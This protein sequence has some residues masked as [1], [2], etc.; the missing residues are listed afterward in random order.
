MLLKIL[1]HRTSTHLMIVCQRMAV[2][3]TGQHGRRYVEDA[4]ATGYGLLLHTGHREIQRYGAKVFTR[5]EFLCHPNGV[6]DRQEDTAEDVASEFQK[7]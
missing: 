3:I 4:S 2:E 7:P 5:V 1:E 6:P